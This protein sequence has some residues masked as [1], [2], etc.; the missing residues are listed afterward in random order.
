[1][2]VLLYSILTTQCGSLCHWF[3]SCTFTPTVSPSLSE[4]G[5]FFMLLFGALELFLLLFLLAHWRITTISQMNNHT[6]LL[7]VLY[8]VCMWHEWMACCDCSK[9]GA[10]VNGC[11]G[12][13]Y[14]ITCNSSSF[15]KPAAYSGLAKCPDKWISAQTIQGDP[16]PRRMYMNNVAL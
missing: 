1:M 13:C 6:P 12:P 8:S 9:Y 3:T 5:A 15:Q 11:S 10:T 7:C 2:L 4:I 14:T 16:T